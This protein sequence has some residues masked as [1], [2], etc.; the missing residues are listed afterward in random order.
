MDE[1]HA[2]TNNNNRYAATATFSF[3]FTNLVVRK[4]IT[5]IKSKVMTLYPAVSAETAATS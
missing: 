3:S 2:T 1:R 5:L 4:L